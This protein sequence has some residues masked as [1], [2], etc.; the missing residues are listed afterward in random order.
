[1]PEK[2]NFAKRSPP[3]II[4][5]AEPNNISPD[6][7]PYPSFTGLVGA[8][9]R[10]QCNLTSPDKAEQSYP[11]T[12][13]QQLLALLLWEHSGSRPY[14]TQHL[15]CFSCWQRVFLG[16]GGLLKFHSG[17]INNIWQIKS[18]CTISDYQVHFGGI[19]SKALILPECTHLAFIA[20]S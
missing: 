11:A 14:P 15:S 1:M 16:L 18:C 12:P 6:N 3:R 10:R 13:C 9:P 4:E 20:V 17:V 7:I 5:L 2:L 8:W 19:I